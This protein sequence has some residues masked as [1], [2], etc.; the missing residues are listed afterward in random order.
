L[1]NLALPL[2]CVVW[3]GVLFGYHARREKYAVMGLIGL[4][5]LL[6]LV[7]SAAGFGLYMPQSRL[8][9]LLEKVNH[10][11]WS[12]GDLDALEGYHREHPD[13]CEV[14]LSLGL[15]HKR[16]QN[17]RT[18]RH[19]YERLLALSPNSYQAYVNIGNVYLATGQWQDAVDAYEHAISLQPV[20]TA[21]AHFNLARA[22]QQR[23][24]F[25][26]AEQALTRAKISAPHLINRALKL[27]SE[28]H[29]RLV[30]DET[31][32]RTLLW[33]KGYQ[34]YDAEARVPEA[35]W[36]LLFTGFPQRFFSGV[37]LCFGVV[38]LLTFRNDTERIA[39]AC[40]ICGQAFCSRCQKTIGAEKI[41]AQCLNFFQKKDN[42][43]FRLKKK[44]MLGINR[45][46]GRYQIIGNILSLFL[47]GAGHIWQA[48][49]LTGTIWLF[50]FF[51]LLFKLAAV[52]SLG[53][54]WPFMETAAAV[55][56]ILLGLTI[57]GYWLAL[58]VSAARLRARELHDSALI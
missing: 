10:G 9:R 38:I 40:P 37:L 8:I 46:R 47:P 42:I 31:V 21:A 18:A 22:Y 13:D 5:A 17:Y 26:E 16:E 44:K 4:F 52:G 12:S 49:T 34:M 29:N 33:Q 48:H 6:P 24:M 45:H 7:I 27:Y 23:Y 25:T 15:I 50:I 2:C 43:D 41:C 36:A 58:F 39:V 1:L 32:P 28:N 51:M 20:S 57:A 35:L 56:M 14:L 19:Y 53:S 30:I 55:E 54:P 3:L 11:Y